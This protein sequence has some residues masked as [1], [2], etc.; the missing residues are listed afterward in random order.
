[1]LKT[2][3]ALTIAPLVLGAMA[4]ASGQAEVRD[5]HV[6][7]IEEQAEED[8]DT[9]EERRE[10]RDETIERNAERREDHADRTLDGA[11]EDLAEVSIERHEDKQLYQSG[12]R[13]R[14]QTLA[15]RVREAE[16]KLSVRSGHDVRIDDNVQA[17]HRQISML[18]SDIDGLLAV[19]PQQWKPATARI[20]HRLDELGAV[21][22]TL[23]EHA[24]E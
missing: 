24:E 14:L 22:E 19:K 7:A 9:V 21:V 23:Q 8:I 1:M 10:S 16:Q 6:D 11:D 17:A 5:A 18:D 2:I 20:E 4:C 3:A 13:A 15:I 12:A